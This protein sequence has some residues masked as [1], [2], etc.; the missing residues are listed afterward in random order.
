MSDVCK[1]WCRRSGQPTHPG[2]PILFSAK[3]ANQAKRKT[4]IQNP[5]K[6]RREGEG[7]G[8]GG[9]KEGVRGGRY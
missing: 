4:P 2:K 9:R 6:T 8:G 7:K 3:D 1:R 5:M